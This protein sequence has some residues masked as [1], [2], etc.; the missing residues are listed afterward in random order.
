MC[1]CLFLCSLAPLAATSSLQNFFHG[2]VIKVKSSHHN[3][4]SCLFLL[5]PVQAR[6]RGPQQLQA[7]PLH[8][9]TMA[10]RQGGIHKPS[11]VKFHKSF[12]LFYKELASLE[13]APDFFMLPVCPGM[14]LRGR[15]L[16]TL[17]CPIFMPKPHP[18]FK[19]LLPCMEIELLQFMS[20]GVGFGSVHCS[21][22]CHWSLLRSRQSF[23]RFQHALFIF[24]SAL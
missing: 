2:S 21:Y 24:C 14:S 22:F 19:G 7:V 9:P 13:M 12:Q 10:P 17:H 20:D 23:P 18:G 1:D 15:R 11:H 4:P 16:H 8:P 6:Q 5:V 3:S